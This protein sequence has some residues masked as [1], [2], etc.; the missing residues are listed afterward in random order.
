MAHRHPRP[1]ALAASALHAAHA[2]GSACC[3]QRPA[4]TAQGALQQQQQRHVVLHQNAPPRRPSLCL[5]G[6]AAP[7]SC[8]SSSQVPAAQPHRLAAARAH[9]LSWSVRVAGAPFLRMAATLARTLVRS[10]ALRA[11]ACGQEVQRMRP[12]CGREPADGTGCR[13]GAQEAGSRY[14]RGPYWSKLRACMWPSGDHEGHGEQQENMHISA[15]RPICSS[16]EAQRQSKGSRGGVRAREALRRE[17]V[18]GHAYR[19]R[20][21]RRFWRETARGVGKG[22]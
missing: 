14:S 9:G 17:H 10:A 22:R 6:A 5:G 4:A 8:G 3:A 7:M 18:L 1:A 19:H 15:H 12:R 16:A 21:V 2:A 13:G 11:G 20:S